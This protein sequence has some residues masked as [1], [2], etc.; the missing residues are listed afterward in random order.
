MIVRSASDRIVVEVAH[1][2][3]CN[4]VQSQ[5]R[6]LARVC[7]M[8]ERISVRDCILSMSRAVRLL[9]SAVE[10]SLSCEKM[11]LRLIAGRRG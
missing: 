5:S 7:N 9:R 4:R 10:W 11:R 1:D 6:G 8:V 2:V 3:A